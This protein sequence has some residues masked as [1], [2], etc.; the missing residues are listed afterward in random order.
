M[1]LRRATGLPLELVILNVTSPDAGTIRFP[2][3]SDTRALA[4]SSSVSFEVVPISMMMLAVGDD[5]AL[6]FC[7]SSSVIA[8]T[9]VPVIVTVLVAEID[10]VEP[11][12]F[13]ETVM[14]A[15]PVTP[16]PNSATVCVVPSEMNVQSVSEPASAV[17]PPDT[18]QSIALESIT[19]NVVLTVTVVPPA[20]A[21]PFWS[22]SV[23]V[24]VDGGFPVGAKIA[25][26]SRRPQ[27]DRRQQGLRGRR[28][29]RHGDLRQQHRRTS[30]GGNSPQSED[31]RASRGGRLQHHA[32][33]VIP[34]MS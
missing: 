34:I 14:V 10:V 21:T 20:R 29:E 12:G 19:P 27:H 23:I 1:L 22:F 26:G 2:S 3:E 18:V 32:R 16:F 30:A 9:E 5:A 11:N 13:A 33:R 7:S 31:G 24:I 6:D 25:V 8:L 15:V 28:G 4:T 17:S